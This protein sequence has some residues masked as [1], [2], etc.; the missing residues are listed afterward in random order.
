MLQAGFLVAESVID[1]FSF[2]GGTFPLLG[3]HAFEVLLITTATWPFISWVR[4]FLF[5][6]T[7]H[8]NTSERILP[9]GQGEKNS[10]K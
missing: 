7:S 6:H 10:K 8:R 9:V 5:G 1:H 3:M 2:W 4:M